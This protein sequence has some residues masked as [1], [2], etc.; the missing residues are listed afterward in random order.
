MG[1]ALST[2]GRDESLRVSCRVTHR[3]SS[4]ARFSFV[5]L[6]GGVE[7]DDQ[8]LLL[9]LALVLKQVTVTVVIGYEPK[10]SMLRKKL[11]GL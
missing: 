7:A 2:A 3:A 11:D 4:F 5:R 9:V 8:A 6:G 10:A 1:S